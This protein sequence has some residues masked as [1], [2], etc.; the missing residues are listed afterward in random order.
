MNVFLSAGIIFTLL[1]IGFCLL[2]WGNMKCTGTSP[3]KT[4]TFVAILFT[5]G[6][7]VGLIM[8]PLTE[9]AGYADHEVSP[10]YAFTNPL[11]IEFATGAF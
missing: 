1:V 8:F 3:V 2:R 11:A 9:F 7:D 10:E 5:S 4:F 6:L